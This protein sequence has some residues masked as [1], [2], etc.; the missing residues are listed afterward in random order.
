[1]RY[2]VELKPKAEKDLRAM[3]K[4]AAGRMYQ[5]PSTLES[6]L[7]GDTKRLTGY[8]PEYRLRVGNWRAL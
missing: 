3:P 8:S 6:G 7:T 4:D 5:A 2:N 1:M